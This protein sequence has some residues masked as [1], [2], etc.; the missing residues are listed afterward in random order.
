M[1]ML[2]RVVICKL[3]AE[4]LGDFLIGESVTFTDFLR[5]VSIVP[6][7][8][9][10]LSLFSVGLELPPKVTIRLSYRFDKAFV[11]WTEHPPDPAR[12]SCAH[13]VCFF[14]CTLAVVSLNF[15][16]KTTFASMNNRHTEQGFDLAPLRVNYAP[17]HW[18]NVFNASRNE[19]LREAATISPPHHKSNMKASEL[20]TDSLLVLV[21]IPDFS[22]FSYICAYFLSCF[23]C[24]NT[25][26]FNAGMPFNALCLVCTVVT[27]FAGTMV[28]VLTR[29]W[30]KFIEETNLRSREGPYPVRCLKS[31][32][33]KFAQ[34]KTPTD[35]SSSVQ[36]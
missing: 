20:F 32:W 18:N 14:F 22:E 6:S 10:G 23:T 8:G 1:F 36:L 15:D 12:V 24:K 13:E 11:P 35:T 3:K 9:Q 34:R 31:L 26:L 17:D 28:S 33:R 21:P 27:F 29:D 5:H 30:A 7:I 16:L 2:R 19:T 4:S 25:S